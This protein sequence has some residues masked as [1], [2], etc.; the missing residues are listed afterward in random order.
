[1]PTAE[2]YR[3]PAD[4]PS[5]IPVFPLRGA[6]LLPRATLPLNIFEPRYLAMIDAVMSG[7]RVLGVIQPAGGDDGEESPM[8]K[9]FDLR[10]VGC[11]GR[12]TTYQELD[13]GRF[14]ITLTG[15]ARFDILNEIKGDTPFRRMR[16]SYDRF[17]DDFQ[18]GR[19]EDEV[20]REALLSVLKKYLDANR[21]RADWSAILRAS[22][23]VLIN[24]LSVMSPYGPEEKQA[25]LEAM[26]LKTRADVLVALAEMELASSGDSS[27]GT[28]Q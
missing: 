5:E 11:V 20:D 14:V 15:V 17:A 4:L 2:L 21:L 26:D 8:G 6:I 24:A 27:G 28:L 18:S 23:E 13:D 25:L 3:R 7:R 10:S 22:S 16:V 12:I 19:G 9:S 1:M